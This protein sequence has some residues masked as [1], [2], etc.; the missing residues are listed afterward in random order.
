ESQISCPAWVK[1]TEQPSLSL[2]TSCVRRERVRTR[3]E[4]QRKP[5]STERSST[6]SGP[7]PEVTSGSAAV[8][9]GTSHLSVGRHFIEVCHSHRGAATDHTVVGPS[10]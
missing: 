9:A 8:P 3:I 10:T 2:P 1:S 7:V 4:R 5:H 6:L